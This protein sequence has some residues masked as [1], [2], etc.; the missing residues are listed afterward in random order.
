MANYTYDHIHI[1]SPDPKA[2]AKFFVDKFGATIKSEGTASN[3]T[4]MVS[5]DFFGS[6][7]FLMGK[8]EEPAG[9]AP[10]PRSVYG[11][12][13]FG[14]HTDD[15]DAAVAELKAKGVEFVQDITN[16]RPGIR[17]SFLK[18]PDNTVI[19]LLERKPV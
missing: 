3:G 12:E 4:A 11:L 7:I 2:A 1:I 9:E 17:I 18:G 16:F 13:H 14:I 6:N 19:E 15:L 10:D 5:V 8:V